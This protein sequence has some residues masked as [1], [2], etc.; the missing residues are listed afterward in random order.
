VDLRNLRFITADRN[1]YDRPERV[2]P[3]RGRRLI[4]PPKLD[5]SSWETHT[6]PEWQ[7]LAAGR[8]LP[9]QGWKIH[10][11]ATQANAQRI[12][13]A[14]AEYCWRNRLDF[15]FVPSDAALLERNGKQ[16]HRG[17]AGK[18]ITIYPTTDAELHDALESL[19]ELVAG[20]PGPY[21]LSD[22]RW[23]AGPL[24]VRYGGFAR[25][26]V[27]D[28]DEQVPAILDPSGSLV[29]DVRGPMFAAPEWV[30]LPDFLQAQRDALSSSAGS[31]AFPYVVQEA[32]HFSNGG[33]V[34]AASRR[35]DGSRVV[36]KEARPNAG[37]TPDGR[38][39]VSR[40]QSEADALRQLSDLENVVRLRDTFT[41]EGHLFLVLDEV[42]GATL[43]QELVQRSPAIRV[44]STREDYERYRDW[45]L[46]I[47][48]QLETVVA[49]VHE[50]G[51]VIGDIHP[52]NVLITPDDTAVLIDF[53]M[54]A[55]VEDA[56]AVVIGAPGFTPPPDRV[57][58]AA[59]LWSL[60]SVE[61]FLFL[62]LAP[63]LSLDPQ[64]LDELVRSAADM[65]ALPS[66]LAERILARLGA[67]APAF[68][69]IE[70]AH[71]GGPDEVITEW[72]T[73]TEDGLFRLQ[74]ALGRAI[75]SSADFSRADRAYPGDPQ[76]FRDNGFGLAYGASGVIHALDATQ[77]DLDPQAITWLEDATHFEVPASQIGLF[78]GLA[79]AAW[80]NRRLHNSAEATRLI[81]QVE[82]E[83]AF[84]LG[85][86]E[87]TLGSDLFAGL[88][89]IGLFLLDE[90]GNPEL[91]D[92]IF[93]E[94]ERRVETG[95]VFSSTKR[96]RNGLMWGPS[97]IALFATRLYERSGD[98]RHL[99]LAVR[100][101]AIDLERCV[102][103]DDGSLHIDEGWRLMPY[104]ASGSA[105]VA[106]TAAQLLPHVADPQPYLEAIDGIQLA[107]QAP[108]TIESSL[109]TGR[110]GFIHTLVYLSRAGLTSRAAEDA[111]D[112][113]VQAL[114]LHALRYK[115]GIMFP[116]TGLLR[117]SSDLA[118]GAAGV[119]SALQAYE[120]LRHEPERRGWSALLPLLVSETSPRSAWSKTTSTQRG[121]ETL[122]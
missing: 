99:Q 2:A 52:K 122:Q 109:F 71:R 19:D 81:A 21:I 8:E 59:D 114:R 43:Q 86:P 119:L 95:T 35:E 15:K 45:A 46:D 12:L 88:A 69:S 73:T 76:Q 87:R 34:Y 51:L 121:G 96:S 107:L 1:F 3:A 120:L 67:P 80:V 85:H 48:D 116:G 98:E 72:E 25:M 75:E 40:S 23:K 94:L 106:L 113:H 47:I 84:R 22:L 28:D 63:L 38:D 65:F 5:W 57:S 68:P 115:T 36:L 82:S 56:T 79:G 92:Q 64:K 62:P 53:E 29:P 100:A 97:G 91:V 7:Y 31:E 78:D 32:L 102:P 111:L 50:R 89:G 37:L 6:S 9:V 93:A 27:T 60:A 105:G 74:V 55:P 41:L 54:A 70:M 18:F 14:T 83:T 42:K 4:L 103:A 24:Y 13:F 90:N 26:Y 44:D 108:F 104:L 20:E 77:L 49:R 30:T 33:G 39:A 117:M 118:T 17:A 110:A 58:I 61:L 16:A 11:S 101:L 10:V 66:S 112:H